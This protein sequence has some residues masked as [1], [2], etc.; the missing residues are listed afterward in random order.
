[1]SGKV[2]ELLSSHFD[3]LLEKHDIELKAALLFM[4]PIDEKAL[5]F[6]NDNPE[7]MVFQLKSYDDFTMKPALFGKSTFVSTD[8][9][10]LAYPAAH[11]DPGVVVYSV[12]RRG[13]THDTH[14]LYFD[15]TKTRPAFIRTDTAS[16]ITN[17]YPWL[18]VPVSM[19]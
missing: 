10:W 15:S 13:N 5:A 14:K 6:I 2:D 18:A 9:K 8:N 16:N 11:T 1:M 17:P 4:I 19:R 12:C 7:A 3:S